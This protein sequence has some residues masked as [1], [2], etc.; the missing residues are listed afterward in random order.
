MPGRRIVRRLQSLGLLNKLQ[1][2]FP[3]VPCSPVVYTQAFKGLPC[4][5]FGVDAHTIKATWML[6]DCDRNTGSIAC[7][8][9]FQL[10]GVAFPGT[11]RGFV[12]YRPS[13]M[14]TNIIIQVNLRYDRML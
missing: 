2:S 4:H 6:W 7:T 3:R 8:Y 12:F 10:P 5:H 14:S 1:L 13:H 9:N 11:L